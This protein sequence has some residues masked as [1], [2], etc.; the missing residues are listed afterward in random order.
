MFTYIPNK[1]KSLVN[2]S[3]NR[4]DGSDSG[5]EESESSDS[6]SESCKGSPEGSV[7]PNS[8]H[9]PRARG[10]D[11]VHQDDSTINKGVGENASMI[12]AIAPVAIDVGPSSQVAR[13][14][15]IKSGCVSPGAASTTSTRE[16]HAPF[17]M[18]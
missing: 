2:E 6:E 8:N 1:V 7:Q 5:D 14:P 12:F 15:H 10:S 17:P 4:D 3:G 18:G 13:S 16:S 9:S 11:D